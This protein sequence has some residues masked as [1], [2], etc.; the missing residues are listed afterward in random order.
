MKNRLKIIKNAA[1]FTEKASKITKNLEKKLIKNC[2]II[3]IDAHFIIYLLNCLLYLTGRYPRPNG[4]H[5]PLTKPN[6]SNS[7]THIRGFERAPRSADR[8]Q[9]D[10]DHPPTSLHQPGQLECHQIERKQ[11]P[12]DQRGGV[13]EYTGFERVSFFSLT[14]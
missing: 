8:R 14:V 5:L 10:R 11:D 1:N 13:P 6:V 4:K 2:T 12:G 9:P 3:I 7:S